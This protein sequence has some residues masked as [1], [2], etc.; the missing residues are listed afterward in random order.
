MHRRRFITCTL[1]AAGLGTLGWHHSRPNLKKV[2]RSSRAL[3]SQ[4]HLTVYAKSRTQGELAIDAALA[5]IDR[6][7]DLMSL[8][9]CHSELAELNRFGAL[10]KPS[11]E[12]LRVLKIATQLSRDTDG[13][14]P[15]E[16]FAE[17]G[18]G[19]G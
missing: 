1:G 19:K 15:A 4:V 7:E 6:V 3:G 10:D 16:V 9:R 2:T 17:V 5:A 14:R 12:L 18:A 11:P 8:Y 13:A